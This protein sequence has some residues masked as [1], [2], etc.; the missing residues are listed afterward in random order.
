MSTRNT[1]DNARYHRAAVRLMA[2][3]ADP[4][5]ARVDEAWG[6]ALRRSGAVAGSVSLLL[7]GLGILLLDMAVNHYPLSA[8]IDI[9]P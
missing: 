5:A 6:S 2:I 8:V 1:V 7:T 9:L 3:D 4:D